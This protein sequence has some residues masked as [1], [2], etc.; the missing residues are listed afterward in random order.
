ML[1]RQTLYR[2]K[3]SSPPLR[4]R[5][6][7]CS[8]SLTHFVALHGLELLIILLPQPLESWNYKHAPTPPSSLFGRRLSCI[9]SL[10]PHCLCRPR[11][12]SRCSLP[13]NSQPG[14][15]PNKCFRRFRSLQRIDLLSSFPHQRIDI[16][17]LP[18]P[19]LNFCPY[20]VKPTSSD[21]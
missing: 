3:Y 14:T 1:P 18:F 10:S 8:P 20:F 12:P 9:V 2:L 15:Q 13:M 17:V 11:G 19:H 6:L 21:S 16:K 5:A 4:G 7:P